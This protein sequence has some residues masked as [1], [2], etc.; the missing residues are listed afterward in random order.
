MTTGMDVTAAIA[1]V[2][3]AFGIVAPADSFGGGMLLALGCSYAVRAFRHVEARKGLGLSLFAAILAA[4]LVAGLHDHTKGVW[5]W[6]RL[7]LQIQ[8]AFV[9]ALSQALFELVAARGSGL[10]GKLAD[11]AGL[12]ETK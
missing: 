3:I 6:G 8:M 2:L 1:A 7:P 12:G 11:K 10:L 5:V 4:M 9:G